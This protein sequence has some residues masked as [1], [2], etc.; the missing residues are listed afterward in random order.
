MEYKTGGLT[1]KYLTGVCFLVAI[2]CLA[3]TG[4]YNMV[5]SYEIP[6]FIVLVIAVLCRSYQGLTRYTKR[7][8]K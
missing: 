4:I 7:G 1:M 2:L 3:F 6:L 5:G 8:R